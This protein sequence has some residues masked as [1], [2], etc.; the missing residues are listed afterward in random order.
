M[1]LL[2]ILE[3][4]AFASIVHICPIIQCFLFSIDINV[5]MTAEKNTE[6]QKEEKAK[7]INGWQLFVHNVS[8][9]PYFS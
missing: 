6:A 9:I 1:S 7:K 2:L 8:K 4:L 5:N 3:L